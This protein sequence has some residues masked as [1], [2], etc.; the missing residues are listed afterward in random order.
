MRAFPAEFLARCGL[1]VIPL[2]SAAI[3]SKRS[4]VVTYCFCSPNMPHGCTPVFSLDCVGTVHLT[5]QTVWR[6]DLGWLRLVDAVCSY[7]PIPSLKHSNH[8]NSGAGLMLLFDRTTNPGV[9]AVIVAIMGTGTG[10]TFQPTLVAFQA[11][12]TKK[13]RAVVISDRNYF[14]CLG[15]AC[16]LAISAALLQAGLA[17]NLP[18]GYEYLSDS[19]YSLPSRSSIPDAAWDGILDAYAK[20]SRSVFILQVPLIGAAFVACL[21]VRDR[22]LERPK[23]PGEDEEMGEPARQAYNQT[24]SA[25]DAKGHDEKEPVSENP[26]PIA[27][28]EVSGQKPTERM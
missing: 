17:S 6:S 14:R 7:C 11:H 13:Q 25:P 22:G 3:L 21:F 15:G 27:A 8:T 23:E 10:F 19:T 26:E 4:R 5:V 24:E 9:I 18:P 12:C 20:A 2:L 28:S 16:G 1:S